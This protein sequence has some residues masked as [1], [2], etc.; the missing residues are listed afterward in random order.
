MNAAILEFR[1]G[2]ASSIRLRPEGIAYLPV[3]NW[4]TPCQIDK[5][6]Q[7]LQT[8]MLTW[9]LVDNLNSMALV[10]YPAFTYNAGKLHMEE[11]MAT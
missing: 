1:R 6:Q 2:V 5:T 3:L 10:L 11:A 9:C 7:Q 4:S 8:Q